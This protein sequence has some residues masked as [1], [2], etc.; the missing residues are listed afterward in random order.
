MTKIT[1]EI[2]IGAKLITIAVRGTSKSTVAS[3]IALVS[4]VASSSSQY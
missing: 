1:K 3:A 2:I 4:S